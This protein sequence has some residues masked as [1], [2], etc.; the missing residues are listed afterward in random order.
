MYC[1]SAHHRSC[2]YDTTEYILTY[3]GS[4]PRTYRR[5][6][7]SQSTKDTSVIKTILQTEGIAQL[8]HNIAETII[9]VTTTI[10]DNLSHKTNVLYEIELGLITIFEDTTALEDKRSLT[11]FS[12]IAVVCCTCCCTTNPVDQSHKGLLSFNIVKP[13]KMSK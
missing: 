10:E 11:V 2:C 1:G 3:W 13:V 12:A 5:L 4:G 9:A 7:C 8:I 6:P